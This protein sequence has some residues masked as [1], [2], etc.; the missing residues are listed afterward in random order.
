M[1]A[2][3]EIREICDRYEL[4][5]NITDNVVFIRSACGRWNIF[6]RGDEVVN[7]RHENYRWAKGT[8]QKTHKKFAENYHD[9]E[10]ETKDFREVVS[11]IV[12]H[13]KKMLRNFKKRTKMDKIFEEIEEN[14]CS[15]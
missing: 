7:L 11:Y 8:A 5:Y 1:L 9:Q 14:Q 12:K 2:D 10:L 15:D 6:L 13:D 4:I 3:D